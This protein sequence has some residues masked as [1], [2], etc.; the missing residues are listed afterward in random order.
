MRGKDQKRTE[1]ARSLR[2]VPTSVEISLW[3]RIRGRQLGGFKFVR[4]EPIG[5]YY[6][7]FVCRDRCLIIELD[8][9]QHSESLEDRQRD[10][11]LRALG[12][13]VVRI[14]NNEVVDNNDGVLQML[15][16]ELEKSPLTPSLSPQAG[17]G[18]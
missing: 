4:Q 15:L 9:G 8:G 16:S 3:G 13:S 2:R 18:G 14:W 10:S 6:V 1:R 11:E 7:D 5:R 12:Y 17:R